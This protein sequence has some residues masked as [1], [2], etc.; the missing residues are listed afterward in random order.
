MTQ[1]DAVIGTPSTLFYLLELNCLFFPPMAV[2]SDI[3]GQLNLFVQVCPLQLSTEVTKLNVV[4][5]HNSLTFSIG[6][7]QSLAHRG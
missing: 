1:L 4:G 2:F 5:T 3:C 6:K 7:V